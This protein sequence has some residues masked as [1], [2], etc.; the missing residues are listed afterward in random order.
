[1]IR[2]DH[3]TIDRLVAAYKE[4]IGKIG[5]IEFAPDGTLRILGEGMAKPASS[6]DLDMARFGS[7]AKG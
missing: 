2:I 6:F 4:N 7:G 1:M 3:A 5:G